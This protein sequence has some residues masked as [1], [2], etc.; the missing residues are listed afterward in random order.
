M[1]LGSTQYLVE[2][3]TGSISLGRVK[4]AGALDEI[5]TAFKCRMSS[6]L[7]HST[8]SDP[9]GLPRPVMGLLFFTVV[10]EPG[11]QP[12]LKSRRIHPVVW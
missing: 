3:S 8:S 6:N 5:L 1:A 4:A 7:V 11:T 9:E 10:Y 12:I 2:M